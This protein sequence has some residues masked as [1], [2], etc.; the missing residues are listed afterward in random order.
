M[1][2]AFVGFP[3]SAAWH[4]VSRRA[5]GDAAGGD[6]TLQPGKYQTVDAGEG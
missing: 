4:A 3:S 6:V 1:V 2:S 5:P